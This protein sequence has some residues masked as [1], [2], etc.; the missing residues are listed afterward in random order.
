MPPSG[1]DKRGPGP[2]GACGGGPKLGSWVHSPVWGRGVVM[3]SGE[4]LR[5]GK[6]RGVGRGLCQER[7]RGMWVLR[8]TGVFI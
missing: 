5:E 2:G 8:A 4:E 1:V 6:V 3:W 7:V